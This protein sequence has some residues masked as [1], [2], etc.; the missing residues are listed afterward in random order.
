MPFDSLFPAELVEVI[1]EEMCRGKTWRA[2]PRVGLSRDNF[3]DP[4]YEAD[5]FIETHGWELQ[6]DKLFNLRLRENL[7]EAERVRE[8]YKYDRRFREKV[9]ARNRAS[10]A[11]RVTSET[12]DERKVRLARQRANWARQVAS[13]TPEE[14]K[15]RL[16]RVNAA[17]DKPGPERDRRLAKQRELQ[18]TYRPR[19]RVVK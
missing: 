14:H 19:S 1:Q 8:R 12:A 2:L 18:A 5:L 4:H 6:A 10:R 13:E 15:A 17:R 11:H 3:Y 9:K 16:A 7:T